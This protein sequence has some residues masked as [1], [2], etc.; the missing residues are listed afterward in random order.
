MTAAAAHIPPVTACTYPVRGGNLVRPMVDGVSIFRRIGE[1]I[2]A[3]RQSVWLTVAF[4]TDDF[5]FPDGRGALFD[6]LDRA[7]SRGVD[8]RLLAWRP[9]PELDHDGRLF[10]GSAADRAMLAARGSPVK[11]RWDRAA[12]VYCQHQKCWMVDAGTPDEIA[13]V[14]GANLTAKALS[15]HDSYIEIAGP[16]ATDVH[17]N[18]VQRWNEASERGAADGNWACD[19]SDTMAFPR[20]VSP[21]RGSTTLQIQRMLHAGRYTDRRPVPGGTPFDVAEG[22]R[23][24]LEQ[25]KQAIDAA[26]RTIYI[27]NQAIPVSEIADHL[28]GALARG[29]EVALLTAADPEPYVYTARRDPAQQARFR[30]LEALAAHR[31]FLLAGI[32]A[33]QGEAR[34]PTYVHGKLMLVDDA[35]ATVG[36]CNLH[37]FSLQGHSELNAA[38][39]DAGLV[40]ALRVALYEKHLGVGTGSLDDLAA[41]RLYARTARDNRRRLESGDPDWRGEAFSF[42][43]T[44]YARV[45]GDVP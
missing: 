5:A 16:A 39:W 43:A 10:G 2:E 11:V 6:V 4:Y 27:E 24:I 1:A 30:S 34:R 22:E 33:R 28:L 17:H 26:R 23:A 19:V 18:F 45:E 42:P 20:A 21:A 38:I 13:F 36:S 25:Y 3:A 12:T 7:A 37:A 44:T 40:R 9:N 31:N 41:L 35:W 14:V 32:A 15:R 29:V 8:V